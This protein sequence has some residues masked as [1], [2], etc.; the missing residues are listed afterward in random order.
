MSSATD[1]RER[2]RDRDLDAEQEIDLG[3]VWRSV[4]VR[5][6]LPVI[7]LVVGAIIGLLV[8]V[9]GGK[10]YKATAEVYLGQPLG[11]GQ[12]SPITSVSTVLGQ[13]SFLISSEAA[14]R[15]AAAKAGLTPA[16]LRRKVSSRPILGITGSKLG[17]AA[18]LLAITVSGGSRAKIAKGANALADVVVAN[19]SRY[20]AQ[21]LTSLQVQANRDKQRLVQTTQQLQ[22][23]LA[24]QQSVYKDKTLS[25]TDKLVAIINFN[26]VI[27]ASSAQQNNLQLDLTQTQQ[28]IA[29]LKNIEMPAVVSPA[30]AVNTG[31]P[32]RRSGVLIGALIGL[33]IG[34]LVAILWEPVA[35][36]VRSHQ[37]D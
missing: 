24:G 30:V 12:A 35:R 14:I 33:V 36:T 37:T 8:A 29:S 34:L 5:W 13:A 20:P 27:N 31:G 11:P 26:G 7:G 10:Q 25:P 4:I 15:R 3:R 16:Q 2:G 23:A 32:S 17:T 19:L 22:A 1:K 18:P 21:K 28:Q 9:S 6:W